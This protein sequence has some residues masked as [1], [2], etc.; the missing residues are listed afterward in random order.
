M[1]GDFVLNLRRG[2]LGLAAAGLALAVGAVP[3]AKAQ[4]YDTYSSSGDIT[5]YGRPYERDPATG[6]QIDTV[7]EQRAVRIADLDL[8]T[9]WGARMLRHRVQR[10][11]AEMCDDLDMRYVT[12]D[13]GSR[14]CYRDAVRDAMAQAE[15]IVGHPLYG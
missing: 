4:P 14:D 15:D 8:N 5:V 2:A 7:R 6:A 9:H 3:P 12:V 13:S 1:T 10:A 11:A